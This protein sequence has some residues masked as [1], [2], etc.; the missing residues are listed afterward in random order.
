MKYIDDPVRMQM[1]I[2]KKTCL[3]AIIP[4][5]FSLLSGHLQTFLGLAL[6][7]VISTLLLRLKVIQIKR[8]LAMREEKA[9]TF[10]RNRYFIEYIIYF[11][12]LFVAQKNP[13]LNFMA[14]AAG[15]FMQKFTVICWMIVDAVRNGWQHKL[16]SY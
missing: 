13:N 8:S 11:V 14:A 1:E 4:L 10:I 15:L 16:D 12:V 2:I 7:L 9:V 3:I 6:G 5:A